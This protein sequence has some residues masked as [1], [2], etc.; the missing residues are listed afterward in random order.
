MLVKVATV[1]CYFN[2]KFH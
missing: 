2:H 1:G